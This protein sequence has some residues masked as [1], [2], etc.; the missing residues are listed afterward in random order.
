VTNFSRARV[1][2]EELRIDCALVFFRAA[3]DFLDLVIVVAGREQ[4][5]ALC[6][7]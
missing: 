2:R 5:E 3:R 1:H 6:F 7:G 4:Q